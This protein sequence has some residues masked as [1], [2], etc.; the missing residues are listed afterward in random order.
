MS[1]RN[2]SVSADQI[3]QL[4]EQTGAGIMECKRALEEAKG[5]VEEAARLL[6]ARGAQVAGEKAGRE[7]RQ[8]LI[9]S[10]VHGGK[11]G[12]L[13][14][15]NCET[16]FVAR[17]DAFR[18]FLHEICLQVASMNPRCVTREEVPP[19]EIGQT[20]EH[21]HEEI[22]GVDEEA[23]QPMQQ[24]HMERFYQEWVLLDQPYVKDP[25]KKVQD[26]LHELV[27]STR[28]NVQIRRF[29]RMT[30]GAETSEPGSR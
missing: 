8:G 6:R 16:D 3:K 17:T 18:Q 4:R 1:S 30:L 15:V 19:E 12:V 10:Y 7:T 29:T 21:L 28:E 20:L 5:K 26:L 25:S 11:I 13:V 24:A 27:N 2:N 14:E 23:S 9:G 22:E